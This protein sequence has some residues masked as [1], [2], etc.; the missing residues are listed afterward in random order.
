MKK[1]LLFYAAAFTAL[2]GSLSGCEETAKTSKEPVFPQKQQV[3]I[4]A[5]A[6][7]TLTFTAEADWK[8]V[9]DKSWCR[10]VDGEVLTGQLS[11]KA[12]DVTVTI[13][14][15]DE[16]IDFDASSA[17]IDLTMNGKTETIYEISR[18]GM[19]REAKMWLVDY[20]ENTLLDKIE[21]EYNDGLS[22]M[23][24]V[25]FSANFDWKINSVPEGLEMDMLSGEA[26][27]EASMDNYSWVQMKVD[28]LP[29]SLDGEIVL[30]DMNGENPVS[31]PVSY[32]G[33]GPNDFY[34]EG[35]GWSGLSF[36]KDGFVMVNAG[37]DGS[38]PSED[39]ESKIS[40]YTKD[41]KYSVFISDEWGYLPDEEYADYWL[42]ISDD[43]KGT[44]TVTADENAGGA[45]EAYIVVLPE[46]L[47]ADKD[48]VS[49]DTFG[50]GVSQEGTASASGGFIALWG[51]SYQNANICKFSEYPDFAGM[52]PSEMQLPDNTYV[53]EFT[54]DEIAGVLMVAPLGFPEGWYA[55]VYDE[56]SGTSKDLF[57]IIP[58]TGGFPDNDTMPGT[59]NAASVTDMT[60]WKSYQGI[61]YDSLDTVDP[62]SMAV[63]AFYQTEDQFDMWQASA[64]LVLVK[65]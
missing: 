39:R 44:L 10:F 2:T 42:K 38:V 62:G 37:P 55:N 47:V 7:E 20:S 53:C 29:Y 28:A 26:G 32:T 30:T 18:P 43:K 48:N 54:N 27:V 13:S 21:L 22:T 56:V 46:A 40:V 52:N 49:L 14:V 60:T 5:G 36:S 1:S 63:L 8:L 19:V 45:R 9:V 57:R 61:S 58:M 11:G 12:S 17:S 35:P 41:M 15:S 25:G 65:R 34:Y 59:I 4:E 64:A 16:G 3:E 33:M 23:L 31:F 50:I 24:K 51:G 6:T